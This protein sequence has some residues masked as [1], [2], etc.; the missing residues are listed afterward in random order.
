M[1]DPRGQGVVAAAAAGHIL[2]IEDAAELRTLFRDVLEEEGYRVT[3]R[4][5]APDVEEVARLRPD[6][7]VLDLLLGD[8]EEAAWEL[9]RRLEGDPRLAAVP[10]VVCSAATHL[11]RRLEA[12][13]RD[14]GAEIVPK[15]FGLDDFLGAVERGLRRGAGEGG[16]V[17]GLGS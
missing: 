6:L 14:L 13:L 15:P 7:I 9:A 10:I 12:P 17:A 11:L 2:V 3:L 5:E 8:D 1:V 16:A 4:A